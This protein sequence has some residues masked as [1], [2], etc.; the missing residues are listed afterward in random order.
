MFS[1]HLHLRARQSFYGLTL[2]DCQPMSWGTQ[3]AVDHQAR[4]IPLPGHSPFD[5]DQH[6]ESLFRAAPGPSCPNVGCWLLEQDT[7][8]MSALTR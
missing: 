6:S 3:Q 5:R 7:K 8:R 2:L 4:L 1:H